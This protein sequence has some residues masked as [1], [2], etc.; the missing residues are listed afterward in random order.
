MENKT[1]KT[2]C[3]ELSWIVPNQIVRE[4]YTKAGSID[5]IKEH[6]EISI[7]H[8]SPDRS[9]LLSLADIRKLKGTPSKE[10]REY[11]ASPE[12][13]ALTIAAAVL[14][15]GSLSKIMGNIF[16]KFNTPPY[17]T[18]LFTDE[19][20]AIEWLKTFIKE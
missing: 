2:P 3:G 11:A 4:V 10:A 17:P 20:Q 7:K 8:F 1:I 15:G 14:I 6:L 12:I 19:Q 9:P 5:E 18:K 16:L 13:A